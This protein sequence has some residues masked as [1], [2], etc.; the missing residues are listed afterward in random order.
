MSRRLLPFSMATS[1]A[2]TLGGCRSVGPPSVPKDRFDYASAIS[3]SWK[4]QMLLNLVKLRYADAPVFLDVSSVIAQYTVQ[5]Q[6]AAG[7]TSLGAGSSAFVNG[8]AGWADGTGGGPEVI[9]PGA[10]PASGSGP[11]PSG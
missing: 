9:G 3:E 10:S 2:L 1:A 4:Q 8:G 11:R 5:A 6:A 7:G